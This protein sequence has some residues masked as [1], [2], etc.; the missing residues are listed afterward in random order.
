MNWRFFI[1]FL[2]AYVYNYVCNQLKRIKPD[3][4]LIL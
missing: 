1:V 2:D 4:Y 3:E